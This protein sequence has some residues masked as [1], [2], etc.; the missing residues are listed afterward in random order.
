[1]RPFK[2]LPVPV[3]GLVL[4]CTPGLSRA[5]VLVGA[6]E[7]TGS[8]TTPA[9]SGVTAFGTWSEALG[10][11]KISWAIDFN[12]TNPGLWTYVYS[13]A[14][15]DGSVPLDQEI[16]H[17]ILEVS[18]DFTADDIRD[19]SDAVEMGDP[20]D[21]GPHPSNPGIPGTLTNAIK[22]ITPAQDSYTLVT[23]KEPVWGD[24]YVKDGKQPK[25]TIDTIAYNTGFGME[26]TS[27]GDNTD[28]SFFT[29][30]VPRPDTGEI[31]QVVPEPASMILLGIGAVG[32][33]GYTRLR[34]RQPKAA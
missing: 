31:E 5:D 14:N 1:M 18:D 22:F 23:T 28:G 33:I 26:P 3:I 20:Q 4:L 6:A 25:T 30:W 11:F 17:W 15:K 8:R 2:L 13:F 10:G 19:G 12:V 34:R 32:F 24:F 16:S 7:F 21:Y 9:T 27:D 29:N